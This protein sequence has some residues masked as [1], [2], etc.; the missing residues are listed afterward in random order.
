MPVP[1]G[2]S[3]AIAR[4]AGGDRGYPLRAGLVKLSLNRSGRIKKANQVKSDMTK[5]IPDN[6][7]FK[8]A[9][10]T[11]NVANQAL[12]RYYLRVLQRCEDREDEPQYIPN[13]GSEVTLEHILPAN[14]GKG[15][16]H[17]TP[18]EQKANV[19]RLGNLVLLMGTVNSK[20]GNVKFADKKPALLASQF[21]L[22]SEA[23]AFTKWGTAEIAKRQE[24]LAELAVKTWPL[25]WKPPLSMAL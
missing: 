3:A 13:P 16:E 19:N 17:L 2:N 20:I 24:R 23:G 11:A 12:A 6:N 8:L 4:V 14:P 9:V 7:R 22:T 25:H 18:E 21:S 10:S 1:K 15:W 5:L